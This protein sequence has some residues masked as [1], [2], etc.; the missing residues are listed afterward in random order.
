MRWAFIFSILFFACNSTTQNN[1]P[2]HDIAVANG[3]EN[4]NKVQM[5]EF[6][7]NIQV[8][9]LKDNSRHWQW[10]PQTNE[11]VFVTDSSSTRFSRTDTSTTEL[12][13]LNA[14]FTNDEYW[15]LF[16]MH[17]KWDS[18]AQIKESGKVAAPISGKTLN[19]WVVSYND[20]DGFTPGDMYEVF[21]DDKKLIQEWAFHPGGAMEDPLVTSW[22]NYDDFNGLMIAQE[23]KSKDGKFHLWF[24]GIKVN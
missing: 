24:T 6:T 3:V 17:M 10:Y 18:G 21:V 14:R 5:L 20:T 15:L 16:P 1:Q 23:H 19:K 12:K 13:N 7:F 2:A 4:F 11:A 8:D 9:T 22:E